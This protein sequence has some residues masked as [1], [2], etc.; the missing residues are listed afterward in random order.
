M[1][2]LDTEAIRCVIQFEKLSHCRVID[3]ILDDDTFYFV[4]QSKNIYDIV[5]KGGENIKSISEKVGKKIKVYLYSKDIQRFSDN[6]FQK[7]AKR[8]EVIEDEGRKILRAW[9][10]LR[11][12]RFVIGRKGSNIKIIEEFLKRQFQ[13]NKIEIVDLKN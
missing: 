13:I 8:T 3:S 4:V 7:K 5:G 9:V 2:S 12:K 11:D 6:L 1:K 10:S